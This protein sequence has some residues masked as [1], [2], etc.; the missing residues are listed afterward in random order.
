MW[1][2]GIGGCEESVGTS[3]KVELKKILLL[4]E[5]FCR[6]SV[7]CWQANEGIYQQKSFNSFDQDVRSTLSDHLCTDVFS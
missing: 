1:L 2:A 6:T 7:S 5:L 4:A 3:R